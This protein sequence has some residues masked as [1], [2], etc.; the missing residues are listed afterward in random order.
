MGTL[1]FRPPQGG[2]RALARQ[3]SAAAICCCKFCGVASPF[4][5]SQVP[6]GNLLQGKSQDLTNKKQN[7]K[8]ASKYEQSSSWL[9]GSCIFA[10]GHCG[11]RAPPLS[12]PSLIGGTGNRSHSHAPS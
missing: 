5:S 6:H 2:R 9:A 1:A 10:H 12:T 8:M 11:A 3:E 7:G 4:S